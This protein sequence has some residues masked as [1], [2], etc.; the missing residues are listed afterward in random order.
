MK[1]RIV[2]FS[3]SSREEILKA[4]NMEVDPATA[5]LIEKENPKK[6][7]LSPSGE[8]V[9]SRYFAGLKKGS[10]EVIKSDI[11]SLIKLSDTLG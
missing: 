11:N 7:V 8:P 3:Q 6:F 4:F 10:L 2:T 1:N 9:E 5:C